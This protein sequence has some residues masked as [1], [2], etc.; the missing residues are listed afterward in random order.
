ME[1]KRKIEM[2]TA[3]NRRFVVRRNRPDRDVA[4]PDCGTT[5]VTADEAAEIFGIS[6]RSI[7]Q[8]VE[9]GSVHFTEVQNGELM[10]CGNS[11]RAVLD[12]E[13]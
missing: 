4:C 12:M 1:I 2:F 13:S 6:Q 11:L 3:T 8:L 10:I 7:F 5:M 9:G